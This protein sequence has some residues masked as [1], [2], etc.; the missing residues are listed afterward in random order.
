MFDRLENRFFNLRNSAKRIFLQLLNRKY[1][2]NILTEIHPLDPLLTAIHRI[3]SIYFYQLFVLIFTEIQIQSAHYSSELLARHYVFPQSIEIKEKLSYS[4]S[5]Q[6]DL[7][8]DFLQQLLDGLTSF[9][10]PL[11]NIEFFSQ[12]IFVE[13]HRDVFVGVDYRWIRHHSFHRQRLHRVHI[14]NVPDKLL[15]A[16]LLLIAASRVLS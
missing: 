4:Q 3:N 12:G 11:L 13:I 10:Q 14:L 6:S 5:F 2:I 1:F 7:R 16:Y 15:V 8:L 9:R